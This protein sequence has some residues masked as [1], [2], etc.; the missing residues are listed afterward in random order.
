M[1]HPGRWRKSGRPQASDDT[2]FAGGFHIFANRSSPASPV[3]PSVIIASTSCAP[4]KNHCWGLGRT[5]NHAIAEQCRGDVLKRLA[6]FEQLRPA[7]FRSMN[8]LNMS[9][10]AYFRVGKHP[11]SPR[12]KEG[13]KDGQV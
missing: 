10:S 4:F 12:D 6:V 8:Q 9:G 11:P 5:V 1:W 7:R 2:E 3:K 13:A